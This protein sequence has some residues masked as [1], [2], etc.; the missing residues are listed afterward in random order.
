MLYQR[1]IT[2]LVL[3]AVIGG[4]MLWSP[5]AFDLIAAVTIG[6][7]MWEWLRLAGWSSVVAGFTGAAV[8]GGLLAWDG[9]GLALSS[10][11]LTVICALATAVWV[12]IAAVVVRSRL[13]G[14]PVSR[15]MASGLGVTLL[16]AAWLAVRHFYDAG[17]ALLMVSV[18]AIAWIADVAAYFAG[19][20]FGKSKLAP[21]ISPGKTWAGVW[22]AVI[23]V[24]AAALA[25]AHWTPGL[26][27]FSS[28]LIAAAGAPLAL[29]LL[30]LVVLV[31]VAGDL[32]ESQLKRNAGM[33]DSS[34]LLPGHG[35]VYDRIDALLPVLPACVLLESLFR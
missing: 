4:A 20:A 19:R 30:A 10:T 29:A 17:G 12:L 21:A 33:K 22:G 13:T 5:A 18:L 35:G 16:S 24:V 3:L 26:D 34:H 9:S 14:F 7:A 28:R 8:T 15:A 6:L 25:L 32:F 2:A 11:A 1:I 23:A 27:L 31:S